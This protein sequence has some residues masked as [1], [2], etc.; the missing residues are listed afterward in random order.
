MARGS[1]SEGRS[2]AEAFLGLVSIIAVVCCFITGVRA[3]F[4]TD[5]AVSHRDFVGAGL[6]MFAA[7]VAFGAVVLGVLRR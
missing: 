5:S 7:A 1:D 6:A 3:F 2:R 4:V